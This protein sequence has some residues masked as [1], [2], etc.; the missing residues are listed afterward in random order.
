MASRLAHRK[1]FGQ[2]GGSETSHGALIILLVLSS[3][4]SLS[5]LKAT[6]HSDF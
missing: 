3:P 6:E 2:T 1:D 4:V 5:K